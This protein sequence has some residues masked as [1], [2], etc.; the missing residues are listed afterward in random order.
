MKKLQHVLVAVTLLFALTLPVSLLAQQA[1]AVVPVPAKK[2]E[3][4]PVIYK[5][6]HELER[7]KQQL[8]TEAAHDFEGHRKEAIAHIDQAIEQLHKALEA[9][10]H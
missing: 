9:D 7:V 8:E 1:P 3:H 4:H 6:I 10:K 2:G 5:S